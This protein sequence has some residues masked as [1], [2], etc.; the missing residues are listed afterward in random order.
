MRRTTDEVLFLTAAVLL[1]LLAL[2]VGISFL[3]LGPFSFAA[4]LAIAALKASLV[5]Y[6][7]MDLRLEGGAV[8][9]AAAAG[10][11]WFAL[12]VAG[13]VSDYAARSGGRLSPPDAAERREIREPAGEGFR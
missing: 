6:V 7:F 8:R 5:A 2:T 13:T 4:A 9:A 3:D 1:G 11:V 12:L 10:A